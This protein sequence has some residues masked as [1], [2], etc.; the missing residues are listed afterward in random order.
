MHAEDQILFLSARQ[1]FQ[2]QHKKKLFELVK[3]YPIQWDK[4][5]RIA[6]EHQIAP[7]IYSNLIHKKDLKLGIPPEVINQF[8]LHTYAQIISQKERAKRLSS[9]IDFLNNFQMRVM[10]VKGI[11][12]EHAVYQYPWYTVSK[13]IDVI[14]DCRKAEVTK[15]VHDRISNHFYQS[16]IEYDFF[17]HHDININGAIP[18]DFDRIWSDAKKI[19]YFGCDVY[20]MTPEDLLISTCINSCRKRYFR[21]KSLFDIAEITNKY[22]SLNWDIFLLKARHYDCSAIVYTALKISDLTLGCSLPNNLLQSL[23][24]SRT[25]V[26]L[27]NSTTRYLLNSNPLSTYP[28]SGPNIL[29]RQINIA[30]LLPY[31]SYRGNQIL[32]KAGEITR[33][34]GDDR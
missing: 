15:E 33:N 21:L 26:S 23:N 13:D 18:I 28:F 29:G 32:K 24:V 31:L 8:K 27:I 10:L 20:M 4:V 5:Y 16:G 30:L 14:L 25:R 9:G 34:Q 6:V 12:L 11:A 3:I 19:S 17:N 1:D 22:K 7:V 2:N